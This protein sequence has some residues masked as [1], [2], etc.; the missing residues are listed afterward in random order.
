MFFLCVLMC[1]KGSCL[2]KGFTT[3]VSSSFF[4]GVT[5]PIHCLVWGYFG[6]SMRRR[7]HNTCAY[8][9]K[10]SKTSL[11]NKPYCEPSDQLLEWLQYV[12][13]GSLD[14]GSSVTSNCYQ[15]PQ[16]NAFWPVLCKKKPPKNIPL[17]VLVYTSCYFY[18]H[19]L[20]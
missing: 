8:K 1:F 7:F 16:R 14:P 2:F 12:F 20:H 18:F 6:G 3:C 10:Y 5:S 17:G 9:V 4:K 11:D 15:D 19:L 13:V